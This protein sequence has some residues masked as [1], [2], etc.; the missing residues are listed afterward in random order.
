[1][2]I[3]NYLASPKTRKPFCGLHCCGNAFGVMG[4]HAHTHSIK[5]PKRR[6][7]RYAR[8]ADKGLIRREIEM[9]L[10]DYIPGWGF[11]RD[12]DYLALNE[13]DKY[14]R[15][16][17]HNSNWYDWMLENVYYGEFG[18]QFNDKHLRAPMIDCFFIQ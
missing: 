14:Y 17:F 2:A 16:E 15:N 6:M 7:R 1:M 12:Y 9:E 4:R 5:N 3:I 13:Q 8:R 10:A 11:G 18:G